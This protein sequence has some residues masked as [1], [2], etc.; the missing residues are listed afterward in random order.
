MHIL[1]FV[2]TLF[3]ISYMCNMR[4]Y[5]DCGKRNDLKIFMDLHAFSNLEYEKLAFGML[6]ACMSVCVCALLMHKWLDRFFPSQIF[7]Q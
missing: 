2:F 5:C 6:S 3:I 1:N 7:V 4:K